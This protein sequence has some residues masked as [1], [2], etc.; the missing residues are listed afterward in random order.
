MLSDI[1]LLPRTL[2]LIAAGC[3]LCLFTTATAA[4]HKR[5]QPKA[6]PVTAERV[7]LEPYSKRIE[8]LGTLKSNEAVTLSA[9]ITKIIQAIHFDDGQRVKQGDILV[10]M[11]SRE[12]KALLNEAEL[13]L[14]E[15]TR[16]YSRI[17][18]LQKR[19]LSSE[20]EL[21]EKRLNRD[22]AQAK[23]EAVR[24]RL[25]DR[26]IIAPFDGVMGLRQI[27]LGALVKPGDT[28]ATLDNDSVM[29]LDIPLPAL[30]LSSVKVGMAVE[31]VAADLDRERFLG[32]VVSIDS[33]INPNTRSIT[34]R[35]LIDNPERRLI[36]GMLMQSTLTQPA[37]EQITI[38]EEALVQEGTQRYVFV[39]NKQQGTT[40]VEKRSVI[41]GDRFAGKVIILSGLSKGDSVVTR[42]IMRLNSGS[43]ITLQ[44]SPFTPS[45][46]HPEAAAQ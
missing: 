14:S 30:Y 44:N 4:Q 35:A 9:S 33:R 32:K 43:H 23:L 20:S 8:A 15:S 16:Q 1:A 6:V 36:S 37:R 18:S 45:P 39:V 7:T 46:K 34:V 10:E 22:T 31:A 29:K 25:A 27:S 5:N 2:H 28:I 19:N 12:E 17:Q 26:T 3:V 40:T 13:L 42:G 41:S 21:D 38:A 11:A 24:A